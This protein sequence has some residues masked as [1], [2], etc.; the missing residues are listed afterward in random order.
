[1]K[2]CGMH[3][4]KC[5]TSIVLIEIPSWYLQF[6]DV[7]LH[8]PDAGGRHQVLQ[9]LQLW[10]HPAQPGSDITEVRVKL[11]PLLQILLDVDLIAEGLGL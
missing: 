5:K 2:Y 11:L 1:M 10:Q 8:V 7:A 6:P 9:P 3:P 4:H